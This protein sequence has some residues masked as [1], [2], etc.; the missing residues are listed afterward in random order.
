MVNRFK[1]IRRI[2]RN[3]VGLKFLALVLATLTFY[4]IRGTTGYEVPYVIPLEVEVEKGIAILDQDP[5]SVEVTFRGSQEDLRRLD[6]KQLKAVVRPKASSPAGSEAVVIRG[7]DVQG[8]SGVRVVKIKPAV[9]QLKYDRE[10]QKTVKVAKPK[11][12][13]TPLIGR[14]EIDYEPRTVL[15]RGPK[16]MLEDRQIV[17]ETQ[18]VDVDGRVESFSKQVRLL[19]PGGDMW[20]SQIEPAEVTVKVSIVTE[21]VS[22][23]WTN[24]TVLAVLDHGGLT[25]MVFDP[26]AVDVSLHGRAEVVNGVRDDSVKVFVDCVGLRLSPAGKEMPV[27]VHLPPGVDVTATLD[28]ERVRVLLRTPPPK[29]AAVVEDELPL[30]PGDAL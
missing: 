20:V 3:N 22:R 27:N 13:G 9:L 29:P 5:M 12:I 8:A 6:Q 10:I 11:T 30:A 28:P 7:R 2:F 21:T 16:R 26:P 25:N 18:P 19:S 15:I 24:V 1:R 23:E 17:V 14:A 4:A